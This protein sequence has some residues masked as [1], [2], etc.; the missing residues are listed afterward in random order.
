ML[1]NIFRWFGYQK[2]GSIVINSPSSSAT[3]SGVVTFTGTSIQTVNG[4]PLP[5]QSWSASVDLSAVQG[6]FTFHV[7]NSA[8]HVDDRTV[9]VQNA[10]PND[11]IIY[12]NEGNLITDSAGAKW[13]VTAGKVL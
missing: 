8:G 2:D 11:T 7:E 12:N 6:A 9:I 3:V 4:N 1:S 13:S 10:S 5:A